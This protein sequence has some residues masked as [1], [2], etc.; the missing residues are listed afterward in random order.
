MGVF[1][2]DVKGY[3]NICIRSEYS[4]M[5][6]ECEYSHL[7]S[8]PAFFWSFFYFFVFFFKVFKDKTIDWS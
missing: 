8:V 5:I 3:S 7:F 6:S 2:K 4:N 1:S